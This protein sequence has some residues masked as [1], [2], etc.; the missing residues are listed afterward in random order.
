VTL[1]TV[2]LVGFSRD[3]P[4]LSNYRLLF[5]ADPV[6]AGCHSYRGGN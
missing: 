3:F 2:R 4:G 5:H 6:V 1:S